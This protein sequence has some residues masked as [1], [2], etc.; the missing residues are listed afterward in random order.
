MMR[1]L[2]H[3]AIS[4]FERRYD[5]EAG[6]LHAIAEHDPRGMIAFQRFAAAGK[7][8]GGLPVCMI[9]SARVAAALHEDCGPC[10]QL[11]TDMALEAGVDAGVL[12]AL[13]SGRLEQAPEDAALAFRFARAVLE[14]GPE[15]DELRTALTARHGV[16]APWLLALALSVARCFPVI[17]RATG[18]AHSCQRVHIGGEAIVP[19]SA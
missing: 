14:R 11:V 8:T 15:L 19:G 4:A 17:K 3:R 2:L 6:Y 13:V 5:Y 10:V 1:W 12:A 7:H 16:N 18:H 9:E